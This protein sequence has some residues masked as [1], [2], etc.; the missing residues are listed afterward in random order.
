MKKLVY[1]PHMWQTYPFSIDLFIRAEKE[2]DK[3]RLR[4]KR[5]NP[6]LNLL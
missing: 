4:R 5:E 3:K 6:N 2:A 1:Y